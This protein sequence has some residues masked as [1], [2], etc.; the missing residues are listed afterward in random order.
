MNDQIAYGDLGLARGME[1][2]CSRAGH[3]CV[4]GLT[5]GPNRQKSKP[6]VPAWRKLLAVPMG[7]PC[8]WGT[9]I[10]LTAIAHEY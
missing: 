4:E 10:L 6:R 8:D 7:K 9:L 5:S 1:G 2:R 3:K